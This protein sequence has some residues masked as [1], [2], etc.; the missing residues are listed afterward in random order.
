MLTYG[1]LPATSAPRPRAEIAVTVS[2]IGSAP[3]GEAPAWTISRAVGGGWRGTIETKT[4]PV[5]HL[6]ETIADDRGRIGPPPSRRRPGAG[7]R[8]QLPRGAQV[9]QRRAP[10][11]LPEQARPGSGAAD[12][13][14]VTWPL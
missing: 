3:A 9:R 7:A 12:G 4:P 8:A 6:H 1:F 5:R 2:P 14:F 11:T 13:S 10:T